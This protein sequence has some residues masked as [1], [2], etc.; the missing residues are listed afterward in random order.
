MIVVH[1]LPCVLKTSEKEAQM[2]KDNTA[3]YDGLG[4]LNS[5]KKGSE[6][7]AFKKAPKGSGCKHGGQSQK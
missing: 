4:K 7:E 3:K 5:L 6:S 1:M 2:A